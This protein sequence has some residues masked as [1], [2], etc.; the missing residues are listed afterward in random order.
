MPNDLVSGTL[1]CRP[2]RESYTS[3]EYY[4]VNYYELIERVVICTER[5]KH[6]YD[7]PLGFVEYQ[8]I[9]KEYTALSHNRSRA[10]KRL[11]TRAAGTCYSNEAI[12][13]L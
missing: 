1:F 3:P 7:I 12:A 10:R 9:Q 11:K 8:L 4:T 2:R 6:L 13:T 5:S